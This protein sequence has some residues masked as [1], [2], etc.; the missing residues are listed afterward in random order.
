M[1]T[2]N[3]TQQEYRNIVSK[4]PL[5]GSDKVYSK[6]VAQGI[7]EALTNA[8]LDNWTY[9]PE[10]KNADDDSVFNVVAYDSQNQ[11]AGYF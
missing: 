4:L 11:F 5:V 1:T 2:T 3:M 9:V 10:P 6:D 7:C 8:E